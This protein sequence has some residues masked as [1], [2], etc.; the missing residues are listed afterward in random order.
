MQDPSWVT[1]PTCG[2]VIDSILGMLNKHLKNSYGAIL[3]SQT[4]R[5]IAQNYALT[6]EIIGKRKYL[7]SQVRIIS[8]YILEHA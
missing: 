6:Y 8:S 5:N 2:G 1:V 3:H 7:H 4:T